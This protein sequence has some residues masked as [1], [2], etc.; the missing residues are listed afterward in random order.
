MNLKAVFENFLLKRLE[1]KELQ[2]SGSLRMLEVPRSSI[3]FEIKLI[4]M[5]SR[6]STSVFGLACSYFSKS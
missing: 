2:T 5:K 4:G 6:N 1:G 3:S